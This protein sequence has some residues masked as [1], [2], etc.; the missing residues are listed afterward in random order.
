[1][2]NWI[3]PEQAMPYL[4]WKTRWSIYER[5]REGKFPFQYKRAGRAIFIY[6]PDLGVTPEMIAN[7]EAQEGDQS[8]ATATPAHA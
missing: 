2:S 7:R 5:I 6:A 3:T 1:M 4:P 8:L